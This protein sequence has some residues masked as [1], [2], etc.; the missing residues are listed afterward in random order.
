MFEEHQLPQ[1]FA[2]LARIAKAV[3]ATVGVQ[4]EIVIH[5]LRTPEHSVV[6]ISGNLTGRDVGA[7]VPDPELLP[8]NVDRFS[9]DDLCY[10]TRTPLGKQLLSSTVWVRDESGHIVGALC[11]NMDFSD[12]QRA[13]DILNRVMAHSEIINKRE[14][15]ETFATSPDE[16]VLIALRDA[17]A[18]LGKLPHQLGRQDKIQLIQKLDRAGVFSFRQA[19]DIVGQELGVSRSSMYNYL[20]DSRIVVTDS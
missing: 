5:D 12:I 7:P 4:C 20:K 1:V 10:K 13:K 2:L 15:I 18:E 8:E 14:E 11:I 16:F 3:V 9:D 19:V 6:A 17:V